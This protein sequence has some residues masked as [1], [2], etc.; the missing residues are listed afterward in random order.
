VAKS[1]PWL[2]VPFDPDGWITDRKAK[3]EDGLKRLDKA[4]RNGAILGGTKVF[5]KPSFLE[6]PEITPIYAATNPVQNLSSC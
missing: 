2:T 3:I 6:G 4:A 1:V 5:Q